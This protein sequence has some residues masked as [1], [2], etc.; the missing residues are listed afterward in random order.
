[1]KQVLRNLVEQKLQ[2]KA[3]ANEWINSSLYCNR[4][5][6]LNTVG[7]GNCLSNACSLGVWGVND[8]DKQLRRLIKARLPISPCWLRPLC[9]FTR[10]QDLTSTT[11]FLQQESMTSSAGGREIQKRFN[12]QLANQGLG[13]GDCDK[14]WRTELAVF[15]DDRK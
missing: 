10:F 1:M 13:P 6:I 8:R 3:E 7:D 15:E 14:E 9:P 4:Q 5:Y 11:T 12:Y 2:S